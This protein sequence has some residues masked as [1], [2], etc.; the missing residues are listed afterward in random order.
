MQCYIVNKAS[1]RTTSPP[2]DSC[3]THIAWIC[4]AVLGI[5]PLG[6]SFSSAG[7]NIFTAQNI[8]STYPPRPALLRH[9][10]RYIHHETP[11][12]ARVCGNIFTKLSS[13]SEVLHAHENT[14]R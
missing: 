11:T 3:V 14:A 8:I 5:S 2:G 13:T 4:H 7:L 10:T 1:R 6:N 12:V 9:M